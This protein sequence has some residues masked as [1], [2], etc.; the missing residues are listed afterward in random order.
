MCHNDSP[1][2]SNYITAT[3]CVI[4]IDDDQIRMARFKFGQPRLQEIPLIVRFRNK[5]EVTESL[6]QYFD[7]QKWA[8]III[9]TRHQPLLM[10]FRSNS[11]QQRLPINQLIYITLI[12]AFWSQKGGIF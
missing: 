6:G 5:V 11:F 7:V 8:C 9:V 4:S 10:G 12:A 2:L 1:L 3:G